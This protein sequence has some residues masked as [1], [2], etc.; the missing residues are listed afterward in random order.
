MSLFSN[1]FKKKYSKINDDYKNNLDDDEKDNV[2]YVY[3][4]GLLNFDKLDDKNMM[5]LQWKNYFKKIVNDLPE[6]Y[7]VKLIHY[8]IKLDNSINVMEDNELNGILFEEVLRYMNDHGNFVINYFNPERLSIEIRLENMIIDFLKDI[9]KNH[10]IYDFAGILNSD[11]IFENSNLNIINPE[12]LNLLENNIKIDE[13]KLI[14]FDD[15]LVSY[16]NII[17]DIY[18]KEIK[19]LNEIINLYKDI[20][21]ESKKIFWNKNKYVLKLHNFGKVSEIHWNKHFLN[22]FFNLIWIENITKNNIDKLIKKNFEDILH[23]Q[24]YE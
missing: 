4:T 22:N 16:I 12:Y 20:W 3:T 21:N 11:I 14:N 5:Y 17:R 10:I 7:L 6:K 8:D 24:F 18:G 19:D 15:K 13:I 23:K 2:F 1:L 9:K